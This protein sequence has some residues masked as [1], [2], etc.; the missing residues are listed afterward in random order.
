MDI[1]ILGAGN[2]GGTLGRSWARRGHRVVFGVR[3]VEGADQTLLEVAGASFASQDEA[4][5]FGEVVALTVPWDAVETVLDGLG[6]QLEN[7]I[8]LDCT[9][10]NFTADPT[11]HHPLSGG[12]RVAGW[13]PGARVVKIFNTTGWE[14]MADPVYGATRATMFFAGDDP[15]AKNV[16]AGLAAE[17]GFDPVDV[18]LLS[19]ADLLESLARLWGKLAYGQ[20]MGRDIAFHL[21]RR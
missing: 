2:V 9:N 1:G 18:G 19:N 10:P 5:V 4:A 16:A 6:S 3:S 17:A 21:L 14:N 8:L 7:K 20:H 11:Q 13:A 12:Q 15:D